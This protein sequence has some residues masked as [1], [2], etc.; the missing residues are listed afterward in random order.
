MFSEE[1][2]AIIKESKDINDMYE[3]VIDDVIGSLEEETDKEFIHRVSEICE[4][5]CVS[6]TVGSMIYY[7]DTMP[8][9]ERYK[10]EINEELYD[11]ISSTG[12]SMKKLFKNFDVED[13]LCI[14]GHNQNILA[15]FGYETVCQKLTNR[16]SE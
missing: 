9:F 3:E 15:W 4:Y 16:L 12:Y 11:L 1:V 2:N 5:G 14:E 8:F 10:S 13:P 7:S 6:G